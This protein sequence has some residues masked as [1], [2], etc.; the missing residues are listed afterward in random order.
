MITVNPPNFL[1]G[2]Y[3]ST[4]LISNIRYFKMLINT[5]KKGVAVCL[6]NKTEK[7]DV[8]LEDKWAVDVFSMWSGCHAVFILI[9]I[10]QVAP[11]GLL[12]THKHTSSEKI[13]HEL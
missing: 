8:L 6:L 1:K 3:L 10:V 4:L 12:R 5:I 2:L 13:Y 7:Q 9:S 11:S